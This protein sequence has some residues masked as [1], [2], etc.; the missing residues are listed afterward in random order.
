[1]TAEAG[2]KESRLFLDSYSAP[3]PSGG[4]R[5]GVLAES[6]AAV[7]TEWPAVTISISSTD[8]AGGPHRE[9]GKAGTQTGTSIAGVHGTTVANSVGVVVDVNGDLDTVTSS[10]RLKEAIKSMDKAS[11]AD[12]IAEAC[13]ILLQEGA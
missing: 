11:E 6:K 5:C 2:R 7:Q 13:N 12:P 10:A 8:V 1:M 4:D 9:S 3:R